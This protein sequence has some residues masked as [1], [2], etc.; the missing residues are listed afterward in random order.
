MNKPLRCKEER[1]G[2][3]T[4]IEL[5]R[6]NLLADGDVEVVDGAGA[7]REL[8]DGGRPRDTEALGAALEHLHRALEL[9]EVLAG[10]AHVALEEAQ[11]VRRHAVERLA[12]RARCGR[13]RRAE[14]LAVL[15]RG[16]LRVV[17]V[18]Q[19]HGEVALHVAH[20]L[21][22]EP[23]PLR[24]HDQPALHPRNLAREPLVLLLRPLRRVLELARQLLVL[25]QLLQHHL[26]DHLLPVVRQLAHLRLHELLLLLLQERLLLCL[27]LLLREQRVGGRARLLPKDARP[28]SGRRRSR[29]RQGK[30]ACACPGRRPCVGCSPKRKGRGR[31]CGS[32][33]ST[34]CCC[35]RRCRPERERRCCGGCRL[36]CC[37]VCASEREGRCWGCGGR[38]GCT[39]GCGRCRP[40]RERRHS[41]RCCARCWGGRRL[42]K[43]ACG[44]RRPGCA[45]AKERC[46]VPAW[47]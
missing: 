43:E 25:P 24:E 42:S 16:H 47:L 9:C 30:Q 45:C 31:S 35:G 41:R 29:A 40:K 23:R 19:L 14:R 20:L 17:A 2:G 28:C 34:R 21:H 32:R 3:N 44:G 46:R 15:A 33:R 12:G 8:G 11:H 7:A 1:K 38:G 27:L 36:R 4:N 37:V 26:A 22:L 18:L 39:R 6:G 13:A 10:L 5:K